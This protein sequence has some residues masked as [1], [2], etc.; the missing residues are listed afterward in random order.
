[1]PTAIKCSPGDKFGR[2]TVIAEALSTKDGRGWPIRMVTCKCECGSIRTVSFL[3][4]RHGKSKSCGC[5]HREISAKTA[6]VTFRTHGI[7]RNSTR[8]SEYTTWINV[9]NRIFK[10]SCSQ[11]KNYGG[12]G[13]SMHA[14]WINDFES[15]FAYVGQR[16]SPK[17]SL[18]RIDVDVNYEPGNVKWSTQ[19]EQQSN[20]RNNRKA[21]LDGE[22][23]TF[24]EIARRLGVT[25]HTVAYRTKKNI[26]LSNPPRRWG[27]T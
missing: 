20:R 21:M 22:F 5:L 7:T 12:R 1:M 11:Y 8:P 23:L 13:I 15:F 3:T 27:S 10:K 18:D 24:T 26:P 14:A 6:S 25:W 9:K 2:F 16:P 17:H 19:K 4:I